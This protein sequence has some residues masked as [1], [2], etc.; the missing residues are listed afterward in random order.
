MRGQKVK[1]L[2][3]KLDKFVKQMNA[4]KHPCENIFVFAFTKVFFRAII[5]LDLLISHT[6]N[7]YNT[8]S[9]IYAI[10]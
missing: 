8:I 7:Y 1:I 10:F 5:A 4:K 6:H 3:I 9:N 2:V